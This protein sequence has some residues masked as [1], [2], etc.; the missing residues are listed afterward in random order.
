MRDGK[1]TNYRMDIRKKDGSLANVLLT[2][3]FIKIDNKTHI[4][5]ITTDISRLNEFE[6]QLVKAKEDVEAANLDLAA[7]NEQLEAANEELNATMEELIGA[8]EELERLIAENR[9]AYKELSEKE[10][11]LQKSQKMAMLGSFNR[12]YPGGNMNEALFQAS[13]SFYEIFGLDQKEIMNRDLFMSILLDPEKNGKLYQEIFE[14]RKESYTEEYG[15]KRHNDGE[16]RWISASGEVVY[17]ER[18]MPLKIFGIAQD[19][20]ERKKAEDDLR[21]SEYLF[22]SL[23]ENTPIGIAFTE[24]RI[25]VNANRALSKITGY[26]LD[27]LIGSSSK[28]LYPSDS[29]FDNAGTKMRENINFKDTGVTEA[30]LMHKNGSDINVIVFW[31]KINPQENP[32]ALTIIVQDIT[33][34]KRYDRE[35]K[36]SEEKYRNLINNIQDGVFRCDLDGTI[37]FTTPRVAQLLGCASVNEIIGKKVKDFQYMPESADRE[38]EKLKEQGELNNYES[39]LRRVDT[40]EP[41]TV[42]ANSRFFYNSE[43]NVIGIEGSFTDIT[44]RKKAEKDLEKAVEEKQVLLKELQHR[45]KNNLSMILNMIELES[46]SELAV[47]PEER[48]N[49]LQKRIHSLANL[50]DY[51]FKSDTISDVR[52]EDYLHSVVQSFLET[53]ISNVKSIKIIESYDPVTANTREATAWGLIINELLTNALKYSFPDDRSGT[54]MIRFSK[55][56][57]GIR[58]EVSDNGQGPPGEFDLK[59]SAGFGFLIVDALADQ[60][61]GTFSFNRGDEYTFTV[62]IPS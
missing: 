3:V 11:Y 27:E 52:L 61:G 17:N 44:E 32:A 16:I 35:L 58:L 25:I 39:V 54:I 57:A 13:P 1:I 14:K 37:E 43:G 33:D 46:S 21:R 45:I 36:E 30:R 34:Q 42:Q 60:L 59:R 48:L 22:R 29:D 40:G 18:G 53:Y 6:Q 2:A 50:Y 55:T 38:Y 4:L 26:G 31:S 8:N 20:T 41:V 28:M 9:K 5:A 19:I 51:L 24:D 7:A 47:N 15:I 23:F 62:M 49:S 12:E 10:Y 56:S